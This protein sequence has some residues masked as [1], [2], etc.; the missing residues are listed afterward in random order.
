MKNN[1]TYLII[2]YNQK[3][4]GCVIPS[5]EEVQG[6]DIFRRIEQLSDPELNNKF[7]IHV[8]GECLVDKS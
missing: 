5:Y 4:A 8:I 1:C 7:A 2:H 6:N 3:I